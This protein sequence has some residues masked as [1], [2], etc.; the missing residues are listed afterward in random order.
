M[1]IGLSIVRCGEPQCSRLLADAI[2]LSKFHCV[3]IAD[4]ISPNHVAVNQTTEACF[5]DGA[6]W[7]L[8]LD[9]DMDLDYGRFQ[10]AF[11]IGLRTRDQCLGFRLYDPF[12]DQMIGSVSIMTQAYYR[13]SG[14]WKDGLTTD[15]DADNVAR[16]ARMGCVRIKEPWIA[17]HFENPTRFQIFKRFFVRGMKF[18]AGYTE[19]LPNY[20]PIIDRIKN[21]YDRQLAREAY[22]LGYKIVMKRNPH[23]LPYLLAEYNKYL[24]D[25]SLSEDMLVCSMCVWGDFPYHFHNGR[26]VK[27]SEARFASPNQRDPGLKAEYVNKLATQVS[28][29]MHRKHKLFYLSPEPIDGVIAECQWQ[30]LD[31]HTPHKNLYKLG[32][33]NPEHLKHGDTFINF[34]MDT[35]ILGP[36]DEMV[37]A[38]QMSNGF[39]CRSEIGTIGEN[40]AGG[41]MTG[42][43]KETGEM[44]WE[45]SKTNNINVIPK[46]KSGGER[47]LYRKLHEDHPR[48]KQ[49]WWEFLG[50]EAITGWRCLMGVYKNTTKINNQKITPKTIILSVWGV[51]AI[52]ELVNNYYIEKPPDWLKVWINAYRSTPVANIPTSDAL[53]AA[54]ALIAS[55]PDYYVPTDV[56]LEKV[57]QSS[58]PVSNEL[59]KN[60]DV[61]IWKLCRRHTKRCDI[62]DAAVAMKI[63][64]WNDSDGLL[65]YRR[66][67]GDAVEI[68]P[69][70]RMPHPNGLPQAHI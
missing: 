3:H 60:N 9:G 56:D 38:V 35:I 54:K 21:K 7:V 43:D 17:K 23:D 26:H 4:N 55:R 31:S 39:L 18:R 58:G 2:T 69:D 64:V 15:R 20:Y 10:E 33:Y 44:I 36:L 42:Y 41:D 30:K 62:R 65:Y 27:Q 47:Y 67:R 68:Y 24:D 13:A 8:R 14:G 49:F 52:H 37:S 66:N 29:N 34:D 5:A 28:Q 6:D 40:I 22:D 32:M 12:I 45:W 19:N 50:E 1:K 63:P 61:E 48:L 59:S 11:A 53:E 70:N 57:M 25:S 46:E 51:W 16:T